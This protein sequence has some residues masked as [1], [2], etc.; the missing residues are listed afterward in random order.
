[1]ISDS[2][3]RFDTEKDELVWTK[4]VT[5]NPYPH[6]FESS[7]HVVKYYKTEDDEEYYLFEYIMADNKGAIVN[8]FNGSYWKAV[9]EQFDIA[10]NTY[11]Y[12]QDV[13]HKSNYGLI[14]RGK[15]IKQHIEEYMNRV[16]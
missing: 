16:P 9:V 15:F 14:I 4:I 1:M 11:I 12:S 3:E 13:H 6:H 5:I 2:E 10:D 7:Y 8:N